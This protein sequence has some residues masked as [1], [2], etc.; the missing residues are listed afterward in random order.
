MKCVAVGVLVFVA[1][2]QP[3]DAMQKLKALGKRLKAAG[4]SLLYNS[5]S[6]FGVPYYPR[7]GS[8]PKRARGNSSRS[9]PNQPSGG[10]SSQFR[11]PTPAPRP[12]RSPAAP[13][14]KV[15]KALGIET[16]DYEEGETMFRGGF[17]KPKWDIP[18]IRRKIDAFCKQHRCLLKYNLTSYITPGKMKEIQ[19]DLKPLLKIK[20]WYVDEVKPVISGLPKDEVHNYIRDLFSYAQKRLRYDAVLKLKQRVLELKSLHDSNSLDKLKD[21]LEYEDLC[22]RELLPAGLEGVNDGYYLRE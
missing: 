20:S 14:V 5:G 1:L 13:P 12:A 4:K 9:A 6:T 18:T 2:L 21:Q 7:K 17:F 3:A 15:P 8:S 19:R 22:V 16:L 11:A 10:S